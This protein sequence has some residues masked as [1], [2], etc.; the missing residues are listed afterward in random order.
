VSLLTGEVKQHFWHGG[1]ECDVFFLFSPRKL[2]SDE[3]C[4][5]GTAARA[6]ARG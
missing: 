2:T 4:A 5:G 6:G 3:T 1:G